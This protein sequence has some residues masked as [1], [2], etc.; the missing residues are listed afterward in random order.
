MK[1]TTFKFMIANRSTVALAMIA[2]LAFSAMMPVVADTK[3]K[4]T[5]ALTEEQKIVH[6]LNRTGFGVRP[7]DVERVR[8]MGIEK[9]LDQQLH[10]ERI[11]D[12][13][14]EARLKRLESLNM[15]IAEIYE[16]YPQPNMIAN[17]LGIGKRQQAKQNDQMNPNSNNQ[18]DDVVDLSKRE[19]RQTVMAYYR[20]HGLK[21]AA[22]E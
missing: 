20:E 10:P 21:L 7:G 8:A 4:T 12:S 17:Q 1:K 6:L 22:T 19:N 2:A 15:T 9:Y 5:R 14:T 16:K 18:A 13:A 3:S 11:N